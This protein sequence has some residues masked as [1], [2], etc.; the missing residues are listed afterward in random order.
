MK[1]LG[2]GCMRFPM[3]GEDV[4]EAQVCR[5]V[6]DFLAAGFTYFDTAHGYI[7]EKSETAVKHCLTDRYPRDKYSLTNKLTDFYF[8]KESDI[9]PFFESQ[10]KLCGMGYFDYYLMHAQNAKNYELFKSCNAYKTASELKAEGKVRHVGISF[11]DS[12]E[13]LDRILNEQPCIE[14]VQIQF[15]Y[16]D[17]DDPGVQSA[18]CLEVCRRHNKPVIIM[19]PVKGGSLVNLP[20]DG[21]K[22]LDDLGGGSYASYAIRY[23]ASF[24]GVFMV[25]SGMSDLK[26]LHDNTSYMADFKPFSE[27]EYEAVKKVREI[28]RAQD[29]IPCTACHYCTDGCPMHIKI[30]EAFACYN[31][32]KQRK[33]WN[34]EYYYD[35]HT[36]NSGKAGDCIKCG[37][38]EAACPQHLEIRKLL[39]DVAAEFEN[40]KDE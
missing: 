11:H 28:I 5:M 25:L 31:A 3:A 35:I 36:Q 40:K 23:A 14:V 18:K 29:L 39:C 22:I 7:S 9:R 2:F 4:D 38:C 34:N 12:A 16:L 19:E 13:T 1:K 37:K 30:P 26:Q 33:D 20:P 21:K 24:E 27:E 8:K 32:K 6:D 17:Y 10:L 15:N